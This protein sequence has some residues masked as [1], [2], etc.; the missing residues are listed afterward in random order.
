MNHEKL[1]VGD[2]QQRQDTH[3]RTHRTENR[4]NSSN[5]RYIHLSSERPVFELIKEVL[6]FKVFSVRRERRIMMSSAKRPLQEVDNELLDFAAQNEANIEHDKE[7]APKRRKRIYEAITQYSMNTQDEA[8]SNS[9]LSYP[10][11]IKKVK[12]RNFMSHENFE[13]ELGPQLNFI[14]GNNGSGKS[15]I[16][17]AITIG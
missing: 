16:L 6:Q 7:Q 13:L 2:E 17:T 14:V 12:L 4:L 15:A 11:Y 3:T 1:I 8:G 5:K 9:N 10:G